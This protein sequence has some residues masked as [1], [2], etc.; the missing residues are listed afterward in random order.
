LG[1]PERGTS[2][3][4]SLLK[5]R[6]TRLTVGLAAGISISVATAFAIGALVY[7]HRHLGALLESARE[8]TQSQGELVRE[9]LA[10]QMLKK[11]R[12]L[13][14]K[15]VESFG[16][17]KDIERVLLLD[18]FGQ[19]RFSSGPNRDG[20]DLSLQ[21]ATCQACHQFPPEERAMSRV[22]EAQN[23]TL[24]RTVVP[25]RNQEECHECHDPSQSTNGILILDRDV[26]GLRAAMNRDLRWMLGVAGFL[27]FFLVL[28]VGMVLHLLVMRRLL[29]FQTTARL[30]ADGDLARRIP[31]PGSDTISRMAREFN[32][33]ADS[34]TGL[35]TEVNEQRDR[36][37]TVI[38]SIGDGIVVL[39]PQRK[40]IA[41]N[42]SFLS[43]T[44]DRRE[45]IVGCACTDVT[46]GTCNPRD[47]PTLRC[48][49]D[50]E[51][52][53]RISERRKADGTVAWEEVQAS[54]IYGPDG[55][56]SRVVEVWRD[57]SDRRAAEAR[58][59]DSHR[60]ASLGLLAS[61]F[62]HEL[63]TP[64]A[65][66]LTCLEGILREPAEGEDEEVDRSRIMASAR[67]A[68]DQI[69]RCRGIT[70]HFLRLSRGQTS[71]G[72]LVDVGAIVR[73]VA[74]LVEPTAREHSVNVTHASVESEV[75][76]RADEGDLQHAL[77]NLLLN[78]VQA[79]EPG[80]TV[81]L[82]IVEDSSVRILV[83][84]DGCGCDMEDIKRIF[85][86]FF[87]LREGGTGLGLFLSLNFVRKWEGDIIVR[88]VPDK[89]STFEIVL[90]S[91]PL[92]EITK[93]AV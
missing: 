32:T 82:A 70:Q 92:V 18:H 44:G 60:L 47:C 35:V 54:P 7:S 67:I 43:R 36:L 8:A 59:A 50:G 1:N 90:P 65:T 83:T 39:D 91:L 29:S 20:V 76:V 42:A 19:V 16:A 93:A 41:A 63:N 56:I 87:S 62:S 9:A 34:V 55:R 11:D 57:I 17:Q 66:V 31:V 33:M 13:I 53:V 51:Q 37:E 15:M 45:D 69:M 61:G 25:I 74:K 48:L 58:M 72:D 4:E 21:S 22:M 10:H 85:E 38:N 3:S 75:T 78:A 46:Q 5:Y 64:L 26:S 2:G 28:A 6:A 24:L 14:A 84:D 68:R 49:H 27:T 71:S 52:Q 88:S 73:A 86:P 81:S 40:I 12:A 23:G 80:G 30:I 77:V 79:C 89:G